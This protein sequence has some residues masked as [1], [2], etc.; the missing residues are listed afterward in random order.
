MLKDLK[1]IVYAL[2]RFFAVLIGLIV[3]YQIYLNHFSKDSIDPFS[4]IIANQSQFL[5]N[6]LGYFTLLIDSNDTKEILF[7]IKG[8]VATK[9]VEGCNA[10]SVTIFF[11]AFLFTFYKGVKT[12]YY[13][14]FGVVFLYIINVLRI[15]F[16]NIVVIE[17]PQYTKMMHDYIF[18][19]IIYGAVVVLWLVWMRFFVLRDENS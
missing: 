3:V 4:R 11:L 12:F 19:S 5:L 6:K 17:K 18:P 7:F 2:A 1:P 8:F 16:F 9:M 10:V 13:A 14:L 15:C